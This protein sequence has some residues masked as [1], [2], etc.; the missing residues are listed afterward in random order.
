MVKNQL[1]G[2]MWKFCSPSLKGWPLSWKKGRGPKLHSVLIM[3]LNQVS[4][5]K[6][7][8]VFLSQ[9]NTLSTLYKTLTNPIVYCPT[10]ILKSFSIK[11][12][13][14]T[15]QFSAFILFV[16]NGWTLHLSTLRI[17]LGRRGPGKKPGGP[18]SAPYRISL[19]H[20]PDT[21]SLYW[22]G[23]SKYKVPAC[24]VL[25]TGFGWGARLSSWP[26]GRG[27]LGRGPR[28]FDHVD[29]EH[30]TNLLPKPNLSA[31]QLHPSWN[32]FFL[33]SLV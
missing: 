13:Q 22:T 31:K 9:I 30:L 1:Q 10:K 6:Q 19:S 18:K 8:Y 7:N 3:R 32:L 25:S 5:K 12:S 4:I 16:S 15:F 24:A 14:N 23:Y 28:G 29:T 20:L 27:W 21:T 33:H 2:F 26:R 11:E 17:G